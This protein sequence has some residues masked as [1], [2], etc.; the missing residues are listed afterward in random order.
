MVRVRQMFTLV[1]H[2]SLSFAFARAVQAES[3]AC[4]HVGLGLFA[5]HNGVLPLRWLQVLQ[6]ADVRR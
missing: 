1:K 3:G 4:K 2:S 6:Q 5:A